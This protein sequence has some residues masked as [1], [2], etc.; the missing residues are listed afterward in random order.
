VQTDI[1]IHNGQVLTCDPANRSGSLALLLREGRIAEVADAADALIA[2][3]PGARIID[4]AGKIIVPGFIN[5]HVHTESIL[6]RSRTAGRHRDLWEK[7]AQIVAA[8]RALTTP[9]GL[10]DLRLLYLGTYFEHLRHGTTCVG[11]FPP[12]VQE[13]GLIQLLQAVDRSDVRAVVALQNWDQIRQARD[14]GPRRPPFLINLGKEDDLTV[15][16]FENAVRTAAEFEIPIL[17]HIAE[18]R[19]DTE[20][21]RKNFQKTPLTILRDLGALRHDT[22]LA[23]VNHIGDADIDLLESSGA[24]VALCARSALFKQTGYPSLRGLF[25][26]RIR[27]CL[28]TDW[29]QTD[30]LAEMRFVA[31]LPFLLSGLPRLHAME[32]LRMATINGAHALGLGSDTGSIERGKRADLTFLE[33]ERVGISTLSSSPTAEELADLLITQLSGRDVTD[34]MITG[35]FYL[36]DGQTMT[37]SG[38]DIVAGMT[39]LH[40]KYFPRLQRKPGGAKAK[41]LPLVLDPHPIE[42]GGKLFE[43]GRPA[44]V[45]E[46][47][48]DSVNMEPPAPPPTAPPETRTGP[49]PELSKDVRREFGD[50]EF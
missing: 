28:G 29:G 21:L 45:E 11:D 33:Y 19:E 35:E 10:D 39:L 7:D 20:S 25:G 50:D 36:R 5:A 27:L 38:E 2:A 4:A 31:Q 42:G 15:Y 37:M 23:H 3:V 8:Q 22:L 48:A 6:L 12:D 16:S 49:Q 1:I 13:R 30:M 26:G 17:A 34:V 41:I 46:E 44:T 24:T 43:E 9:E 14:L 40:R 18:R 32:I 47:R